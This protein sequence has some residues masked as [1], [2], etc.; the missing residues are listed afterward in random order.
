M[1][2]GGVMALL[3]LRTTVYFTIYY[4]QTHTIVVSMC[5]TIQ[6]GINFILP[7][8]TERDSLTMEDVLKILINETDDYDEEIYG[9]ALDSL[10]ERGLIKSFLN[11]ENNSK[12]WV[13]V[14][15]LHALSQTVELDGEFSC[16]FATILNQVSKEKFDNSSQTNPLSITQSDLEKAVA[17][18]SHER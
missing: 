14:K 10:E 15:S 7:I 5:M 2:G 11:K 16:R 8:F 17:I 12:T 13:L 18:I 9:L 6:D 3:G 1:G 4:R